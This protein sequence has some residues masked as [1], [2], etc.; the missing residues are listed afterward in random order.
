MNKI[1]PIG[2]I[3]TLLSVIN[4]GAQEFT[5]TSNDLGGQLTQSQIYSEFGCSGKNISPQL[6]WINP[7]TSAFILG[8]KLTGTLIKNT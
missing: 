6:K 1:M 5:L 4:V 8:G 7:K 2:V 3:L